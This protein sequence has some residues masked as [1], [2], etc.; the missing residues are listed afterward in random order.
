[1]AVVLANGVSPDSGFGFTDHLRKPFGSPGPWTTD[2]PYMSPFSPSN[3]INYAIPGNDSV[4]VTILLYNVLGKL[5][6]TVVSE[7]QQPGTYEKN[8]DGPL[9]SS[10]SSGIYFYKLTAG[11]LK[12]TRKM[13]I[14]K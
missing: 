1:M 10:L 6:D 3:S 9:L 2:M 13:V 5:V 14:V 8:L 4:F 7:Y 11:L 12:A